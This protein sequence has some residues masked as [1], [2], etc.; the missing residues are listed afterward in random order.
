MKRRRTEASMKLALAVMEDPFGRFYGYDL[1]RRANVAS[2]VLYPVIDRWLADGWVTDEWEFPTE[3]TA[4]KPRRYYMLTDL[5]RREL[6]SLAEA[7]L[8]AQQLS[9]DV[10]WAAT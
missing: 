3:V 9:T 8:R 5:G 1:S 4:K 10:G 6:G 7:A 2:G